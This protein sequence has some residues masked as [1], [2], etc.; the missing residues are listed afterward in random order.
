[1]IGIKQIITFLFLVGSLSCNFNFYGDVSLG[2]DFYY[3]VEPAFNSVVIPVNPEKPFRSSIYIIQDVESIGYDQ[4]Y[5]LVSSKKEG[6]VAYWVIDKTKKKEELGY[7]SNSNMKLSNVNQ[8]NFAAF[9]S[10]KHSREIEIKTKIQY[11]EAHGY[12]Y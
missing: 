6:E 2:S 10:L 1:M 8:V 5:V 12:K 11:W 7:D 4:K 9:D 3:M